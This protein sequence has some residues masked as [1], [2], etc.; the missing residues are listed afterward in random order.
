MAG[1]QKDVEDS[2]KTLLIDMQLSLAQEQG[3]QSPAF[4]R[5]QLI[6][7]HHDQ[8]FFSYFNVLFFFSLMSLK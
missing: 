5:I 3:L 7:L 1:E 6:K 2:M 8:V 4:G